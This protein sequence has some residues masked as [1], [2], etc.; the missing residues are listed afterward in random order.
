MWQGLSLSCVE[1]APFFADMI[2]FLTSCA[3]AILGILHI[4]STYYLTLTQ[5][6]ILSTCAEAYAL[7]QAAVLLTYRRHVHKMSQV[8]RKNP[9]YRQPFLQNV[10][11]HPYNSDKQVTTIANLQ[12]C[13]YR[14]ARII[15]AVLVYTVIMV[16]VVWLYQYTSS[17]FQNALAN[18]FRSDGVKS[19]A[20]Q[21]F[22]LFLYFNVTQVFVQI[23]PFMIG[24]ISMI[25]TDCYINQ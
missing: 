25:C 1:H 7:F 10:S 11:K 8:N 24:I 13:A 22:Q 2:T 5:W 20:E 16:E 19:Y 15:I 23:L 4:T 12:P 21:Q 18:G 17:A 3:F 6:L 9:S 14:S